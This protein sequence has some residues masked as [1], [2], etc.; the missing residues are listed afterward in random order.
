VEIPA[1]IKLLPQYAGLTHTVQL[2]IM[3]TITWCST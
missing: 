1:V 2:L 3:H